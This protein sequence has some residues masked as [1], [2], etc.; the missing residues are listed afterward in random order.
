[1]HESSGRIERD[2]TGLLDREEVSSLATALPQM[3]KIAA[4]LGNEDEVVFSGGTLQFTVFSGGIAIR[5][6][7]VGA[8][9]AFFDSSGLGRIVRFVA[10]AVAKMQS[11]QK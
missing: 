1:V 7:Y 4:T 8:T 11:L 10:D 9:T 2:Q 6:R 3:A 5:A